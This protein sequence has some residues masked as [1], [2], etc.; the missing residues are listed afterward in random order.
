[1]ISAGPISVVNAGAQIAEYS[2]VALVGFI[3]SLSINLAVLNSLPIPALD[4]GQM[5]FV[6]IELLAQRPIPRRAQEVITGL[7]F[8]GLLLF[9]ASTIIGDIDRLSDPIASKVNKV[10][11]S[12]SMPGVRAPPELQD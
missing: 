6:L 2:P 1:M 8:S 4:G 5:L 9:G 12:A 11:N 10:T 7:A 3:A